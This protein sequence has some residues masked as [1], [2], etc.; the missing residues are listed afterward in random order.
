MNDVVERVVGRHAEDVE[1]EVCMLC[2]HLCI[3][4]YVYVCV[5][6]YICT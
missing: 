5:Y 2:I 6:L 1:V 4:M 3:Y